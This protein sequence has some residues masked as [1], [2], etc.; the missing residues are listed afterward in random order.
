MGG[1][2][3]ENINGVGVVE[4]N[5]EEIILGQKKTIWF[6][7]SVGIKGKSKKWY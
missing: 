2:T 7:W 1:G 6:R 3:V 5:E 4:A